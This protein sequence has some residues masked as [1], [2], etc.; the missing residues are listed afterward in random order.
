MQADDSK[1][2]RRALA[3]AKRG[4][5][6]TSPN[7][8]VGA[9]I[10]RRNRVLGEGWHRAAGRPHAEVEAVRDA[11][12]RGHR[13]RGGT[14]YVTLEPCCTQG[15]TPPCT[16]LIVGEGLA[17]VVVGAIDPNPAHAG[18]GLDLL[19][20][21]GVEVTEGVLAEACM[22]LNRGFN[23]WITKRLP[24]VTLKLA[25]TADG[26]LALPPGQGRW[27]TG[28]EARKE[29]QALRAECDAILVGAGT[30]RL[31]N[32]KLTV[33]GIRGARQPLRVILSRSGKLPAGARV[34]SDRWQDR[35]LVLRM[36]GIR[37][38]LRELGRAGVTRV[39]VEGGAQIADAFIRAGCVDELVLFV[40]PKWAGVEG[41]PRVSRLGDLGLERVSVR[42]V[43]RDLRLDGRV[44]G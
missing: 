32:P 1:W 31:D 20:S 4:L 34:L 29:V 39:L 19:R 12:R 10:V 40:A 25:V 36:A 13:V 9:V 7:P 3:L 18:R 41:L 21:A 14:L 5:G 33:R 26:A 23:R 6:R 28:R 16:D 27:L 30:V 2:M 37:S 24:W 22:D 38:V 11:V 35:T 43:G 44:R 8:C 15:R 42:M 17:R